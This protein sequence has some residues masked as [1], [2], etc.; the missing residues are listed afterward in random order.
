MVA[1]LR[2]R[3]W[4]SLRMVAARSLRLQHV[5][6]CSCSW[7][8]L[9]ARL[10][11][12][13]RTSGGNAPGPARARRILQVR[14]ASGDEALAPQSDGVAVAAQFGGD[15]LVGGLIGVSGPQDESAAEDQGLRRGVS[16][17]QG[18]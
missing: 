13:R 5:A 17:D 12:W 18:L 9:L 3:A 11:T 15:L 10:T 4:A 1:R 6:G 8:L 16:A 2:A 7:V 14:Q